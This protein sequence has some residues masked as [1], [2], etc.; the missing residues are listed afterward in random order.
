MLNRSLMTTVV[1]VRVKD[2]RPKWNDLREWMADSDNVYIGR[3]GIILLDC[4]TGRKERFPAVDSIW[5]NPFKIGNELTRE[6]VIKKYE[7]YIRA[8]IEKDGLHGELGKLRG[9]KLGCWCCPSLCHGDVLV[10]LL[11]EGLSPPPIKLLMK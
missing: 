10:K 8:K 2:I 7:M 3:R 11:A 1:S 9:K 6:D 5:A 4:G